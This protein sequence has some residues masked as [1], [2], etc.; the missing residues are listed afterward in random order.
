MRH[1]INGLCRAFLVLFAVVMMLSFTP[2]V[3]GAVVRVPQE[4]QS[5]QAAI[6]SAQSGDEVWVSGGT[7]AESITLRSGI[8][9]YGGFAG[10]EASREERD[11]VVNPTV[12]DSTSCIGG[13]QAQHVVTMDRVTSVT[14]DGFTVKGGNSTKRIT[15]VPQKQPRR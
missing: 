5:I 14:L 1:L 8:G 9:V 7:Y 10:S 3:Q 12:L 6:D 4:F 13:K 11:W 15:V 2:P